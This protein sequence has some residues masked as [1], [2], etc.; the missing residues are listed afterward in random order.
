MRRGPD[1]HLSSEHADDADL[2]R[3]ERAVAHE[4][5]HEACTD[6]SN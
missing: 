4:V 1:A 2:V 6:L 3:L 5:A